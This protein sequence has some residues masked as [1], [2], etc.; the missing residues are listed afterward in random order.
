MKEQKSTR[1]TPW[2]WLVIGAAVA[3]RGW[4]YLRSPFSPGMN[5][6]YYLVQARSILEKGAL[7]IPDM[8]LTFTLQAAFAW[9]VQ[10]MGIDQATAIS[11]SVKLLDSLLPPLVGLPVYLLTRRWPGATTLTALAGAASACCGIHALTMVGDFEKNALAVMWLGWLA[12]ALHTWVG[13]PSGRTAWPVILFA[14]L[15]G[16]T[17]VGTLGAACG[18]SGLVVLLALLWVEKEQRS[19]VLKLLLFSAV[20]VGAGVALVYAFFDEER[21]VRLVRALSDP[22]TI[23]DSKHGGMPGGPGPGKMMAGGMSMPGP[24]RGGPG[25]VPGGFGMPGMDMAWLRWLPNGSMVFCGSVALILAWRRRRSLSAA[26]ATLIGA[27]ALT[28]FILGGPWWNTDKGMRFILIAGLPCSIAASWIA[29]GLSQ[30]WARGIAIAIMLLYAAGSLAH[31]VKSGPRPMMSEEA[32]EEL[33]VIKKLV[34]PGSRSLIVARHGLEWWVSWFVGTRIAQP[35]GV[36][37]SDWKDYEAVFY[38]TEKRGPP[39]MPGMPGGSRGGRGGPMRGPEAPSTAQTVYDGQYYSL[40][41]VKEV[42]EQYKPEDFLSP[43]W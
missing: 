15:L 40:A 19:A 41:L 9:L 27:A 16:L 13:S 35:S 30:R 33:L 31:Y 24:G 28:A 34:P 38:L 4:I 37:G 5:G 21:A 17:H 22:S 12:W 3:L 14:S 32:R 23:E 1:I 11:F 10:L 29:A 43:W 8:P 25:F 18:F 7:G 26:S 36:E 2:L 20:A 6:A 42:P 39:G